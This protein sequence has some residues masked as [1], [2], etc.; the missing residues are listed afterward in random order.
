MLNV[1][2]TAKS[3][4]K[5][6]QVA[7]LHRPTNPAEYDNL[8]E[9]IE[10]LETIAGDLENPMNPY[11][12]LYELA[13]TYVADYEDE[14]EPALPDPQPRDVLEYLMEEHGV[15]QKDLERAGVAD[16]PL[17]S[18]VLRGERNVSKEMAKRLA[19]FFKVSAAVFL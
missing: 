9:L 19:A 18:K 4:A 13:S 6:A 16:Q 12:P 1:Q 3:W 15:S 11:F 5:F 14:H 8:L 7:Q 10:H 17:I 2:A